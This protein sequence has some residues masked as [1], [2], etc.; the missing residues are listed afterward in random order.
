M[1]NPSTISDLERPENKWTESLGR[2][3]KRLG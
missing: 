1:P 3:L 2:R